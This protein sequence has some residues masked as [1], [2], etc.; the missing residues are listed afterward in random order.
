MQY[1]RSFFNPTLIRHN[2]KRFWPLPVALLLICFLLL[3][4]SHETLRY[5]REYEVPIL[6]AASGQTAINTYDTGYNTAN[7]ILSMRRSAVYQLGGPMVMV[8]FVA[9]LLSALLVMHHI[10]GR[11][12]LQFYHGL[13][14]SRRCFY[15][16]SAVSGYLLGLL[17]VL[18]VELVLI[19]I[20]CSMG[21]ELLPCLQL[22]G[23]T[24]SA[25][26]IF[27]S[28]S[29]LACVLAGQTLGAVL[30][31]GGM[32]CFALA[33]MTGA[34]GV[35]QY[36]LYGYNESILLE[37]VTTCLTPMLV[38][39]N[40]ANAAYNEQGLPYGFSLLPILIYFLVGIALLVLGGVLYQHRRGEKTGEMIAFSGV[41]WLCRILVALI[42][43][44][45]G[46]V[47]IVE[48][49]SL[50]TRDI[51][52][53]TIT[54]MV[55]VLMFLGWFVAEMVVQKSF[56]VFKRKSVTGCL[57][58]C[59]AALLILVG[60][61]LDVFGYVNHIPAP[62][63]FSGAN[64]SLAGTTISLDT[65]DAIRLHQTILNHEE[66]LSNNTGVYRGTDILLDYYQ[67]GKLRMT[68]TYHV[69][70]TEDNLIFDQLLSIT[71]R[72]DYVRQSWLGMD[73]DVQRLSSAEIYSYNYYSEE[74]G[75]SNCYLLEDGQPLFNYCALPAQDIL[76][77]Y[78]AVLQDIRAGNL[79][80]Q[81]DYM[82]TDNSRS[83][84][85]IDFQ[86]IP[87]AQR[88]GTS[89]SIELATR[90]QSVVLRPT[91]KHTLDVLRELGITVNE[92]AAEQ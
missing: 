23:L 27:Y 30:L 92:T 33:V 19:P 47:F 61:N 67:D 21:C 32:N 39:T 1:K 87:E 53:P 18:L 51:T 28:I 45:L 8:S 79:L 70:D 4:S 59:V 17:P 68:R 12:Q 78:E 82:L 55:L 77:V 35:A 58:L 60:A 44:L 65:E 38:M 54:V 73:T 49:T 34:A 3:S 56:R 14:L 81:Y 37:D 71:A 91:M 36:V 41:K 31:C 80:N 84:G 85:V 89:Y 62:E 7:D 22:I 83:Y 86:F 75:S 25:F 11:K 24:V 5:A 66:E 20:A 76:R 16:T 29:M 10:H 57:S 72:E 52:F 88:T 63:E 13:P 46:T 48:T 90:Y 64:V 9:A 74:D 40:A 2:L 50:I 43:G 69:L 6:A 15:I 42:A 26:T